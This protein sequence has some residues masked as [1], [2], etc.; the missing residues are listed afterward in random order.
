MTSNDPILEADLN[1]YVDDQLA[2]GRRIE[3]EAYLSERPAVAAQIMKDLRVR[4][5]LRLALAD[6][7]T[8]I[9]QETRE[10]ARQLERSLSR[11]RILAVF[12]RAAAI[13]LFVAAGWVAH[14]V[15]GPFGATEV[16]ASMQ[17][18]AFVE[19]AVRAHRTTLLRDTMA[20]QPE[21]ETF[22]RAEIRS[23]TAIVLPDLP[24]GWTVLDTQVFPSA[25]GP[26]VELV[27]Q[28]EANER[29]SLFAVR[30]GSFAVQH[31]L[32]FHADNAKAA[33]WQIGDVAYA[34]VSESRKA[35]DLTQTAR[36]LSRTLY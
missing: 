32:L 23:A 28:P 19:E 18:P 17:P 16:I 24:K 21:T 25:Y 34:L 31:V 15:F 14:A 33:Y 4:D 3:V 27:L 2:V 30:P 10:A 13:A 6:H 11:R 1:A 35:D 26:S 8:V 12:R 22:D 7:R 36:E 5:E 9:R 29:L 20:S